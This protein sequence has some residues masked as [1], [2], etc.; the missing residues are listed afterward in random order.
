MLIIDI[1]D[2]YPEKVIAS[3]YKNVWKCLWSFVTILI[4]DIFDNY[5]ERVI[6]SNSPTIFFEYL[7]PFY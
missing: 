2:S 1:L 5:P 7:C 6:V 3:N 4:I